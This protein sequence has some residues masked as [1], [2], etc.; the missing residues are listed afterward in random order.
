MLKKEFNLSSLATLRTDKGYTKNDISIMT[1]I[2]KK[3]IRKIEKGKLTP[4]FNELIKITQS[5]GFDLKLSVINKF[6]YETKEIHLKK[7]TSN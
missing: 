7:I 5:L 3:N 6:T 2:S 4:S 1:G